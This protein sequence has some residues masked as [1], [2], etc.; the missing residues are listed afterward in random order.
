MEWKEGEGRR[1][2]DSRAKM[3]QRKGRR[4]HNKGNI[5]MNENREWGKAHMYEAPEI[6]MAEG[7]DG[8]NPQGQEKKVLLGGVQRVKMDKKKVVQRNLSQCG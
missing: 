2:N 1:A 4:G 5:I 7:S 6:G 8:G 3:R